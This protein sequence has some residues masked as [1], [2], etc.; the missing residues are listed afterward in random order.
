MCIHHC[1]SSYTVLNSTGEQHVFVMPCYL[2]ASAFSIRL[3]NTTWSGCV[4][5][6]GLHTEMELPGSVK[7]VGFE[8]R[9]AKI[10]SDQLSSRL[11]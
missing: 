7:E 6:L 2:F 5:Y 9:A 11:S 1:G 10:Q 4:Q 3:L 8:N